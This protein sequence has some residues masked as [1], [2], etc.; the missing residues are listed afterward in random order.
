MV[1]PVD[2]SWQYIYNDSYLTNYD[3]YDNMYTDLRMVILASNYKILPIF[4]KL[5]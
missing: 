2:N 3:S 5:W 1:D 4:L